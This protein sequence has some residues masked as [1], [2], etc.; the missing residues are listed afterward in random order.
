MIT[1]VQR[2]NIAGDKIEG[3]FLAECPSKSIRQFFSEGTIF[4]EMMKRMGAGCSPEV[5]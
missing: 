2:E 4:V 5:D 3:Y 1:H